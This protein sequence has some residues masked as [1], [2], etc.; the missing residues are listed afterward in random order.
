MRKLIELLLLAACPLLAIAE[1]MTIEKAQAWVAPKA[2]T[3]AEVAFIDFMVEGTINGDEQILY[4]RSYLQIFE[5]Y[6]DQLVPDSFQVL[7]WGQVDPDPITLRDFLLLPPY[8]L[9]D[10]TC[11]IT[12]CSRDQRGSMKRP[13]PAWRLGAWVEAVAPF[14]YTKD[15]FLT[16]EQAED[17][18]PTH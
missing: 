4:G 5:V 16:Y 3:E 14:G 7:R 9:E 15:D 8:H 18:K 6:L 2:L 12:L 11:I 17:L 10:G 1:D 13:M